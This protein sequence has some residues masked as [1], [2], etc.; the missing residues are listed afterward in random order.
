MVGLKRA[1]GQCIFLVLR[2]DG[3]TDHLVQSSTS[4]QIFCT[5]NFSL[6]LGREIGRS[7]WPNTVWNM[8]YTN[9]IWFMSNVMNNLVRGMY[10]KLWLSLSLTR[11]SISCIITSTI[12]FFEYALV[13]LYSTHYRL[14]H[15]IKHIIPND[16]YLERNENFSNLLQ[17][18]QLWETLQKVVT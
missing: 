15:E 18:N 13:K 2:P 14:L 16:L 4:P 11:C 9:K 10:L 7:G 1:M 5:S 12:C 8:F 17:L 3:L 6:K